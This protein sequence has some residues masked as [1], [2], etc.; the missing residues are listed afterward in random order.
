[1]ACRFKD[2]MSRFNLF[3]SILQLILPKISKLKAKFLIKDHVFART[4]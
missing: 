3:P 4:T 2:A 1:M